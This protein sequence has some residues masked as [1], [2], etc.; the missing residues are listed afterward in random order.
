M[1]T[2]TKQDMVTV[3]FTQEEAKQLATKFAMLKAVEQSVGDE[4]AATLTEALRTKVVHASGK[5]AAP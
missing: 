3:S 1:P 2:K 5:V 4:D